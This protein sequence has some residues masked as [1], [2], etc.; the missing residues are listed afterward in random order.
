MS[1]YTPDKWLML[2]MTNQSDGKVQYKIFGV[3]YGGYPSGASWQLNSGVTR[4]TEDDHG[5]H[6][7]GRSGSV[8]HC[9]RAVYGNSGYGTSVLSHLIANSKEFD[10]E[11][12][13]ET[14]NFVEL[15]Y[16]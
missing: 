5:Y 15:D 10:I 6:F 4:V 9:N 1:E 2:Q 12:M 8:Y 13:P 16:S 7:A 14:T 3:W 11:I